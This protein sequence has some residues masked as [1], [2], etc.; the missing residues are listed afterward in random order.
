MEPSSKYPDR[1]SGSYAGDWMILPIKNIDFAFR[2]CPA[3][4]FIMGSPLTEK[5]R[6]PE[7]IQH[8]VTLSKGF[9]MGE[10]PITQKQWIKI[11]GENP[12]YFSYGEDRP[13]EQVSWD[14]CQIYVK[15][16]NS[17]TMPQYS[18]SLPTEAQ[19]EY[20]CRAG[21]TTAYHFGETAKLIGKHAWYQNN[22]DNRTHSVKQKRPNPWGLYDMLGNVWE[23]CQDGYWHYPTEDVIDP[24]QDGCSH[25][26]RGG[27]NFYY[28]KHCR[29]ADR[30][31]YYGKF[32]NIQRKSDFGLRIILTPNNY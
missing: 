17:F 5:R 31:D 3:G 14:D 2:W 16:L 27:S 19:W 8:R 28:A 23:W 18:V 22:S 30:G 21:T 29:S 10:T 1:M 4:T 26:F 7:E 6:N 15:V 11:M 25:V 20:A 13:V 24:I 9:W 12:C 32:T